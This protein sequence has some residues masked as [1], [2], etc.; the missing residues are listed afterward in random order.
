[1]DN[2]PDPASVF[3]AIGSVSLLVLLGLS[4]LSGKISARLD[5]RR[6]IIMSRRIENAKA[7]TV[8]EVVPVLV[9]PVEDELVCDDDDDIMPPISRRLSDDEIITL[10]AMQRTP[11]NRYRFSANEIAQLVKHTRNEVLEQVRTVRGT[12]PPAGPFSTLESTRRPSVIQ[13]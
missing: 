10:L 5:R 4:I 2:Q 8:R 12:R 7:V 11:E 3:I 6:A 13:R 1:M 9:V